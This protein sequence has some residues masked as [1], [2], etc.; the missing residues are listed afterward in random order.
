[1][2][3]PANKVTVEDVFSKILD[4][5][6][7]LKTVTNAEAGIKTVIRKQEDEKPGEQNSLLASAMNIMGGKIVEE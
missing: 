5:K 1:L 6:I 2:N 7:R 4:S 3:D